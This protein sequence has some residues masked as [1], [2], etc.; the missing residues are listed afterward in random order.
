MDFVFLCRVA[1]TLVSSLLGLHAAT[2]PCASLYIKSRQD[3]QGALVAVKLGVLLC[4]L[5]YLC[6]LAVI[7]A[8]QKV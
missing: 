8:M 4:V 1:G 7:M 3:T 5:L 2:L 6:V